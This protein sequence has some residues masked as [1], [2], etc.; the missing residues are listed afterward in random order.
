MSNSHTGTASRLDIQPGQAVF[1]VESS[2]DSHG[3]QSFT[4]DWMFPNGKYRGQCF[5]AVVDEHVK[6]MRANGYTVEVR[7]HRSDE[8]SNEKKVTP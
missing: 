7:A 6:L 1:T 3:R 4:I 5:H 8:T 2:K